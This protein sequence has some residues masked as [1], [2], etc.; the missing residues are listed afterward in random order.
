MAIEYVRV[1][2]QIMVGAEPGI[3]YLARLF[4]EQDIDIDGLAKEVSESSTVSYPDVLAC[5]KAFEIVVSRHIL[6]GQAVK[7]PYLGHFIP[8][9]E[10]QAMNTLSQVTP[11][12]V[13]RVTCR[14]YPSVAFTRS[15][16]TVP[17]VEKNL[18]ITGL[19]Q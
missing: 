10:A 18:E 9:I 7:L 4:R 11:E 14:F 13:K 6:N 1:K 12:T 15:L 16:K 3:K 19:Q 17:V 8:K 2:R 5:L